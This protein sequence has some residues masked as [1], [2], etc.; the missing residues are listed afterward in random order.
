MATTVEVYGLLSSP[1]FQRARLIAEQVAS[2]AN[3]ITLGQLETDWLQYL[4]A[5]RKTYPALTYSPVLCFLDG[6][7]LGAADEL[8]CCLKRDFKVSDSASSDELSRVASEL[9]RGVVS[10]PKK[11]YVYWEVQIGNKRP[12][13][14]VLELGFGVCPVTVRN[15]WELATGV[16]SLTYTNCSLHRVVQGGFV[17]GGLVTNKQGVQVNE[18]IYGGYFED[19][20]YA[21]SHDKVGVI[22]MSKSAPHKN[23]SAFYITLRPMPHLDHRN[24]AF[25]RVVEGMEV[26]LT[27]SELECLNQRPTKS[28]KITVSTDYISSGAIDRFRD[29]TDD[30]VPSEPHRSGSKLEAADLDTLLKKRTAVVKEIESM[31]HELESQKA[32]LKAIKQVQDI[33]Q[34]S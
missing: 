22:G 26:F 6:V 8:L 21:Y 15:F 23:G 9:Y 17:E 24:V 28:C 31:R 25:G 7:L 18:S 27:M 16:S 30:T 14:V 20:N 12:R 33:K 3:V 1:S 13:P 11:K 29:N 2:K 19:E 4:A 5:T 32:L 34:P 10:N